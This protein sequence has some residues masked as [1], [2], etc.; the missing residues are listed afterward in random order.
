MGCVDWARRAVGVR[1]GILYCFLPF[2]LLH[3][4]KLDILNH[5]HR[6][7]IDLV[8]E[9]ML[10]TE[11]IVSIVHGATVGKISHAFA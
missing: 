11:L 10:D 3:L 1:G 7:V 8:E 9:G 4:L 2:L 5:V 6:T